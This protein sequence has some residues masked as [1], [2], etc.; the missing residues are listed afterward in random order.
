LEPESKEI[1]C[2]F[3]AETK[4][5]SVKI[6]PVVLL[7]YA[8]PIVA[9]IVY[10]V[11]SW[12]TSKLTMVACVIYRLQRNTIENSKQTFP[13]KELHGLSP[14]VHIHVSSHHRSAYS[15]TGKYEDRAWD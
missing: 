12:S 13:E 8:A 9:I 7:L 5:L 4:V 10:V 6:R 14:K 2:C 1:L 15:A 3:Q 11:R